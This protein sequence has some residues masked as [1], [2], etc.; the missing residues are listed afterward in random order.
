[1]GFVV[2][3]SRMLALQAAG[4]VRVSYNKG[5]KPILSIQDMIKTTGG[6]TKAVKKVEEKKEKRQFYT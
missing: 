2:A 3:E 5:E 6:R 1:V 4:S